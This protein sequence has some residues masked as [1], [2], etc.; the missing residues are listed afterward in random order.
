MKDV[1]ASFLSPPP[2]VSSAGD[3]PAPED[4]LRATLGELT[5]ADNESLADHAARCP[6]CSVAWCLARDYVRESG[7]VDQPRWKPSRRW[8]LPAVAA[9][10][11]LALAV[12]LAPWQERTR[13]PAPGLRESG[14]IAIESLV[15]EA[16]P[17]AAE[18]FTLRWSPGPEGTRYD[19]RVTDQRLEHLAGAVSLRRAEYTVPTT[20][21]ARLE[22]GSLV[23]WQVEAVLP[24][25]RRVVSRTFATRLE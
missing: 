9:A 13:A 1:Q 8:W 23:L 18:R 5:H 21:L 12:L 25:K 7:L 3:C 20:V 14:R 24:D 19:I 4:I 22:P 2:G 6:V 17:L 11:T 10:A 15:P 16:M